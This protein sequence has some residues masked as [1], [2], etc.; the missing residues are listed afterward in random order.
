MITIDGVYL[1]TVRRNEKTGY[2]VFKF[3]YFGPAHDRFIIYVRAQIP[4]YVRE[5]PL[6][7]EGDFKDKKTF[8][9][10][11]VTEKI[12][13]NEI[14]IA[15]LS[16]KEFGG[17]GPKRAKL[18]VDTF[19]PDIFSL[20][21]EKDAIEKISSLKGITESTAHD[22]IVKVRNT[23]IQRK[24]FEFLLKYF[25]TVIPAIKLAD[26]Y[27]YKAFDKLKENPYICCMEFE[28]P[29]FTADAIAR[30]LDFDYLDK[31][32]IE[33][34]IFEA[35]KMSKNAGNTFIYQDELNNNIKFILRNSAFHEKIPLTYFAAAMIKCKW[36]RVEKDEDEKTRV[37]F[38]S[39][40][41]SENETAR[42][43]N[44]LRSDSL[45]LPFDENIVEEIEKE[46]NIKYHANQKKTF[47]LLKTTG[48][49]IL[50]GGPGTG[51][52][53]L[54]NGIILAFQK[55][56]P[57]ARVVLC[58]PTG[59]AAQR[60]SEQTGRESNTIHKL[61]EIKPYEDVFTSRDSVNPIEADFI[62]V[63]EF[64]M[65]DIEIMSVF[66]NAIKGRTLVL[67]VGDVDQIPS[68]GPGNVMRDLIKSGIIETYKLT[69]VYR[70]SSG[71]SIVDNAN[72]IIKGNENLSFDSTFDLIHLKEGEKINDCI[73]LLFK[74]DKNLNIENT[75]I[76]TTVKK[77]D[78]GTYSVNRQ[79]QKH[80]FEERDAYYSSFTIGDKIIINENDYELGVFN[81]DL[82]YVKHILEDGIEVEINGKEIVIPNVSLDIMSLAYAITI[83]KSQGSEFKNV[84][85]LLPDDA[86]N[87][88]QRNLL[89]TA[90]TRAKE[91]IIVIAKSDAFERSIRQN[92]IIKRNTTLCKR[93][94]QKEEK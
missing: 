16:N 65:I 43:I 61:L 89:Y 13:D 38:K 28:V 56:N 46:T 94:E 55:L 32:R 37:Y 10:K 79:I 82:G 48:I 39:L 20:V 26:K 62:I 83:H 36:L 42:H 35:V 60:M 9:A 74:N 22:L 27:K 80:L 66:L 33:A 49:K 51:K 21:E 30:D 24:V 71:S 68:V 90:V 84:I 73:S 59:R 92:N 70:Q 58:S 44:R 11:K 88:L 50:T 67:F 41:L 75:Q 12:S 93:L 6:R 1:S 69:N 23:I 40:W 17:I 64:S 53:T 29:F 77:G 81:G 85:I 72:K 86:N 18:I 19:G 78:G 57:K 63:D 7:I 47:N 4:I 45:P 91:R 87:M 8:I 5:M 76:L 34:I 54:L 2:T 52:T 31:K 15:Y 25:G 3:K 14:S